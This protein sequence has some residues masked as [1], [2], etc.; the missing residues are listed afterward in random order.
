[1]IAIELF[2]LS[3]EQIHSHYCFMTILILFSGGT[4]IARENYGRYLFHNT[5][6]GALMP[7]VLFMVPSY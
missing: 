6:I 5:S 1:M 7:C 2:V 3:N 4:N